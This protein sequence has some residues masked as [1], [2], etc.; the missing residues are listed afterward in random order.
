MKKMIR[1]VATG[2][3]MTQT[4]GDGCPALAAELAKE[5]PD[6]EFEIINQG[7]G[8]TR[9]GYGLWRMTNEYEFE[10][11]KCPPLVSLNPDV[12]ILESFAY[13]NATDG[14]LNDEGLE[15]FRDMH[16]KMVETIRGKTD[17]IIIFVVTIAPDVT[18]FLE[19][20]PSFYNTPKSILACMAKERMRYQE[21]AIKI[22]GELQLPLV[23]VYAETLAA[24]ESGTPLST[25]INPEDCIHPSS[26][27]HELT[28]R[29]TAEL[30]KRHCLLLK[31]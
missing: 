2:D 6:K 20:V 27:G 7:V 28:A 18:H 24:K 12:V 5:Y 25:F 31:R 14:L 9:A 19:S 11:K 29:L 15:H 21:E 1:I 3:S 30:M 22:A 13:N 10:K 4:A 17:A 8:G 26:K 23:N 16:Y